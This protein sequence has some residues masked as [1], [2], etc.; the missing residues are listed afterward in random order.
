MDTINLY[1][2]TKKFRFES[3]HRLGKGYKG[4]CRNLHG[5]SWNGHI[6]VST[7]T[8][9]QFDMAADFSELGKFCKELEA[10]LDHKCL[11]WVGDKELIDY[12]SA[13]GQ[14]HVLFDQLPTCETIAKVV[15]D[16]LVKHFEPQRHV[17]VV[18]VTIEET[19][20]TSC[21]FTKET[22]TIKLP[23]NG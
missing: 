23:N 16:M 12:L 10:R 5:H 20:T 1:K 11:V 21:T 3:A 7:T 18:S 2:L 6:E 9:D 8:T 19:C 4:K 17:K 22:A 15:Y 13:T 14:E